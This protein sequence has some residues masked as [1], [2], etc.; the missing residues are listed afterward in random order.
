MPKK[1]KKIRHKK[2][3]IKNKNLINVKINIDNSKKST[4]RRTQQ[5]KQQ[6][7]NTQPFVNFP[8]HQPARIQIL[9]NKSN[10]FSSPDL[11]KTMDEY[12]KQFRTYLETSD[13]NI[14][15]M[16]EK[17]DDTLKKNIAPQQKQE[18]ESKPGASNVYADT[19]GN[20][21][22]QERI[23]KKTYEVDKN[24]INQ[25]PFDN[26]NFSYVNPLYQSSIKNPLSTKSTLS[27]NNFN[28]SD[29][30]DKTYNRWNKPNEL[31]ANQMAELTSSPI[32]AN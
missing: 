14:K 6:N 3:K 30:N 18:P 11:S 9:E 23:K 31:K 27:N 24:R 22:Y 13:Q 28:V 12:Q 2:L 20:E 32:I 21:V 25:D 17:Y 10:S 19:E 26:D 1:E 7:I 29:K 5:P 4:T 15:N 16:I 8:S